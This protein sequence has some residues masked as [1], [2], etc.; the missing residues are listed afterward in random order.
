MLFNKNNNGSEEIY[1]LTGTFHAST[2]F[3]SIQ[4]DVT[5]AEMEVGDLVGEAVMDAAQKDYD[6]N[7]DSE[8]LQ[9]V[10]RPIAVL[11]V[12]YF[13]RKTGLSVGETGR[14]LKVDENEKV[15]FEWMIDRDN[16][17]MKERYYRAIDLLFRFLEKHASDLQAK[18]RHELTTVRT[19][20]DFE[21]VYPI[22][23]S[24]YT[25]HKMYPL[26]QEAEAM[27]L[28]KISQDLTS[29][30]M[31]RAA[32]RYVVLQ[33]LII[34]LKRWSLSV[35]PLEIARQ[36]SPSHEGNRETQP[37]TASE[38]QW[39][40]VQFSEQANSALEELRHLQGDVYE[41]KAFPDNKRRNKFF[42][43]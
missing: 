23:G 11:A 5:A 42:T 25:L 13:A 30:Q 32:R 24:R 29:D 4:E 19:I 7:K 14:K 3:K 31:K 8:L 9:A 10:R 15:P 41:G 38:I 6:E 21:D 20:Q 39:Q 26:L 27:L 22:H 16:L 35:F 36:F 40:I 12:A 34:A 33:A 43:V 2:D 37:A 17:E 18:P 1:D 28:S